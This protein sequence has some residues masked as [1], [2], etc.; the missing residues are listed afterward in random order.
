M[1]CEKSAYNLFSFI[2]KRKNGAGTVMLRNFF[3]AGHILPHSAYIS[4]GGGQGYDNRTELGFFTG[5]F[6]DKTVGLRDQTG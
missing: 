3:R 2:E 4:V 6:T 1:I 5:F